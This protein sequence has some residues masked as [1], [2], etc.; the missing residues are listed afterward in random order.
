MHAILKMTTY[1]CMIRS[2]ALWR[3]VCVKPIRTGI[4][5]VPATRDLFVQL[6]I[7][8]SRFSCKTWL[9]GEGSADVRAARV[10][11]MTSVMCILS[12]DY[13]RLYHVQRRMLENIQRKTKYKS[14]GSAFY[15]QHFTTQTEEVED[16]QQD[17]SS[18]SKTCIL[19]TLNTRQIGGSGMHCEPGNGTSS[20]AFLLSSMSIIMLVHWQYRYPAKRS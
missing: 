7:G 1:T 12:K 18:T 10:A 4:F 19:I 11:T 8:P 15:L 9:L 2:S 14:S 6:R 20:L 13:A 3:L 16:R 5:D 17:Y